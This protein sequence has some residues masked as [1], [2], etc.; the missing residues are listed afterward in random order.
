M[1]CYRHWT[2]DYIHQT[3]RSMHKRHCCTVDSIKEKLW[4]AK[5]RLKWQSGEV[6]ISDVLLKVS[7]LAI[8]GTNY[9]DIKGSSYTVPTSGLIW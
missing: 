5:I 8:T 6:S 1:P 3:V 4:Q 2:Q 9:V 7:V